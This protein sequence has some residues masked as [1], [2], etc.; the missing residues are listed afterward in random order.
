[1]AGCATSVERRGLPIL[2]HARATLLEWK[3]DYN[4]RRPHG[5]LD[6]LTPTEFAAKHREKPAA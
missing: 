2:D 5:S 3:L 1:M 6:D 4:V